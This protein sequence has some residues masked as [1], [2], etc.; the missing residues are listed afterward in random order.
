MLQKRSLMS[1]SKNNNTLMDFFVHHGANKSVENKNNPFYEPALARKYNHSTRAGS[2]AVRTVFLKSVVEAQPKDGTRLFN[3]GKPLWCF[4]LKYEGISSDSGY[5]EVSFTLS[6]KSRKRFIAGEQDFLV[7]PARV[8]IYPKFLDNFKQ[9]CSNFGSLFAYEPAT[10]M[11]WKNSKEES[12]KNFLAKLQEDNPLKAGT[13][14]QARMGFFNPWLKKSLLVQNLKRKF[15]QRKLTE[16]KDFSDWCKSEENTVPPGVIISVN[17]AVNLYAKERYTVQFGGT[18][19]D[20]LHPN[21][22]KIIRRK[23]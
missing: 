16:I 10:H 3:K 8:R 12:Y 7:V 1:D 2:P 20:D 9:R 13:L 11:M 18:V 15:Q 6:E 4:N 17:G 14:V 22:I 5:R 21:E 23:K 19:Y